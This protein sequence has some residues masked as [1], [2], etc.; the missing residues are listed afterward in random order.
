MEHG[1][2]AHAGPDVCRA[3][4]EIAETLIVGDVEFASRVLSTLSTSLNALLIAAPSES[5][6]SEMIFSLIM[7]C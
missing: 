2:S 7:M 4:G 6:A 3:G 5:I 1:R